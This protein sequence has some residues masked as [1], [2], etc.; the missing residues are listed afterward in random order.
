MPQWLI[1]ASTLNI[2]LNTLYLPQYLIFVS[3]LDIYLKKI[4][5]YVILHSLDKKYVYILYTTGFVQCFTCQTGFFKPRIY[6]SQTE[7]LCSEIFEYL[8]TWLLVP[9]SNMFSTM[10][11]ALS[12]GK[13]GGRYTMIC[14]WE[15]VRH[16]TCWLVLSMV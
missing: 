4:S 8:K 2:C 1:F 12:W 13:V 5:Y 16:L 6:L 11:T 7:I 9:T 14:S 15:T 3:I 10:V